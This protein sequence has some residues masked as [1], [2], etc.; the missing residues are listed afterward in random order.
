MTIV[1]TPRKISLRLHTEYFHINP[2]YTTGP[3]KRMVSRLREF[4]RQG[5]AEV[6]SNSKNKIHQTWELFFLPGPVHML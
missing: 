4:F 3:G 5:Q 1:T 6:V 2:A